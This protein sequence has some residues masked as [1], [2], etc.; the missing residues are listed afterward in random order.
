MAT[1]E[2]IDALRREARDLIGATGRA[3]DG[4]LCLDSS[5]VQVVARKA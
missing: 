5:Y 3:V 2:A 1:P 4:R